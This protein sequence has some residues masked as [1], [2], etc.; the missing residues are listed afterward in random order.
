VEGKRI[1]FCSLCGESW[2]FAR[3]GCPF[4]GEVGSVGVVAVGKDDPRWV[5]TCN[6]CR[7]YIKTVDERKLPS[8]TR[9]FPL[10]ETTSTLYLDLIA[11]KEG[12][13]RGLPSGALV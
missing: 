9:L 7:N 11:E 5:E 4:C 6:R 12:C 3:I 1:L 8:E 13:R 10:V 2:E